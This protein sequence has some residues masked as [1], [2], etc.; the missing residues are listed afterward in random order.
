MTFMTEQSIA[1]SD[2]PKYLPKRNGKKVHYS[3]IYRWATKGARGKVLESTLVGGVRYTTRE[4]LLRFF[5]PD[6]EQ[7]HDL[8][9]AD[10]LR[11]VLY[12]DIR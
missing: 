12:G 7:P 5:E 1:L 2:A 11:R 9:Q 6:G 3:T 4:A 10:E 8:C